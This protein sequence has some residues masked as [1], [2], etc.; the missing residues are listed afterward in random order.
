[1]SDRGKVFE[2]IVDPDGAGSFSVRVV[3]EVL[4]K[5]SVDELQ[6]E[7]AELWQE[8]VRVLTEAAAKRAAQEEKGH[9]TIG[10]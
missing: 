4:G 2:V 3:P 1:M 5:I 7:A 10:V 6:A 8:F 9:A